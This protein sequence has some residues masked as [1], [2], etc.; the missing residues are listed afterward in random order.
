VEPW[1]LQQL[2][3]CDVSVEV[4]WFTLMIAKAQLVTLDAPVTAPQGIVYSTSPRKAEGDDGIT[5]FV[6]GP[7]SEVVFSEVVGCL[8]AAEAGLPAPI[9]AILSAGDERFAGTQEVKGAIR[10]I[11][12]WMGRRRKIVNSADLYNIIV[13]DAWLANYDR[14]LYNVLGTPATGSDI[15]VVFIDF[16]KSATLRRNPIIA[17][18][19][20]EPRKLWPTGELGAVLKERKPLHPPPATL[21]AIADFARQKCSDLL[22]EVAAELTDVSWAE[23]SLHALM[24]RAENIKQIVGEV[25]QSN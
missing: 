18:T 22:G 3:S 8:L 10:D 11:S 4:Q 7:D 23:N 17:A 20:I 5:Y 2:K 19:M 13:V 16:E 15:N 21:D 1:Q 14:N 25:W 6:K 24:S 12:P 9:P